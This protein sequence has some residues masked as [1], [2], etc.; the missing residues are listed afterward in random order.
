MPVPRRPCRK[1]VI[2][3]IHVFQCGSQTGKRDPTQSSRRL[4]QL[5]R[6]EHLL[7]VCAILT[8]AAAVV[9][10]ALAAAVGQQCF[11]KVHGSRRRKHVPLC[12]CQVMAAPL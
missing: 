11:G 5:A 3:S 12:T 2:H 7:L 9:G 4:A 1:V 8:A 6:L 10:S